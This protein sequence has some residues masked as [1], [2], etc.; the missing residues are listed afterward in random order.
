MH[1]KFSTHRPKSKET[2]ISEIKIMEKRNYSPPFPGFESSVNP[3]PPGAMVFF[4]AKP[5][6]TSIDK[7][8][9]VMPRIL[10]LIFLIFLVSPL[11]NSQSI[12]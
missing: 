6:A 7:I 12:I 9:N 8:I 2:K 10:G 4:T 3:T 11:F 5:P 1:F